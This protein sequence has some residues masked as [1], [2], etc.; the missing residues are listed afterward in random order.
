MTSEI[1]RRG[2]PRKTESTYAD[3]RNDLIRS[4]LELLTQNGFLAT[5]VDAIVKNAGV[6]KGSFYYYFKSKEE[7]AQA[8]LHAYDSFFEHKLKKHLHQPLCEPMLRLENFIHDAC[9]GIKKYNFTRGCLVGNMMQESPGL[10]Q[11]FIKQLQDVLESWQELVAS[12]LSDALTSGEIC[13]EMN[14]KQLAAI[15]WSGWEGA[16]M[17]S[18]L[19]SSTQ[20]VYDFWNYF[21]TSVRYQSSQEATEVQ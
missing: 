13:S 9:N 2:R 5:G 16:V 20:P 3:T 4:G 1:R 10:P 15:F 14:D 21:K 17:R 19:Y 12:C 6:P 8:V 7:Y 11:S 18:K